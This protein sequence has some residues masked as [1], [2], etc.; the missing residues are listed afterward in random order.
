MQDVVEDLYEG[1]GLANPSVPVLGKEDDA[2]PSAAAAVGDGKS[3]SSAELAGYL[4][5]LGTILSS[6]DSRKQQASS[7]MDYSELMLYIA[8]QKPRISEMVARAKRI[9]A[10]EFGDAFD[11][12]YKPPAQGAPRSSGV[13]K[14]TAEMR[15]KA[16][17]GLAYEAAERLERTWRDLQDLTWAVK[18]H[19]EFVLDEMRAAGGQGESIRGHVKSPSPGEPSAGR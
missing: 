1:F 16:D 7:P 2:S 11:R 18:G 5:E 10:K 6:I 19:A 14:Q 13:S 17:A 12:H 4:T 15:A 8:G 3:T 9:Y